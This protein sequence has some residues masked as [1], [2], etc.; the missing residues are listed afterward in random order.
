MA[1]C[2]S[3]ERCVPRRLPSGVLPAGLRGHSSQ[4]SCLPQGAALWGWEQGAAP[5]GPCSTRRGGPYAQRANPL[6]VLSSIPGQQC[7][8]GQSAPLPETSQAMQD[9]GMDRQDRTH[10]AHPKKGCSSTALRS[11]LRMVGLS[12]VTSLEVARGSQRGSYPLGLIPA[13]PPAVWHRAGRRV[14]P[15]RYV[16]LQVA[17]GQGK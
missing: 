14:L 4:R 17:C 1:G 15:H 12:S 8:S 2:P 3:L 11:W 6:G 7:P 16:H 13:S 9:P 5:L 10:G